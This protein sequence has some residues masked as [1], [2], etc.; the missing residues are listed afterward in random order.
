MKRS[1]INRI[2]TE[3]VTALLGQGYQ[4]NVD[5]MA[6][7]Q[8]EI[9]KVDLRKGDEILRVVLRRESCRDEGY[10]D[11]FAIT[12]GRNTDR[13]WPHSWDNTV[14]D[15]HLEILSQI[16][17]ANITEEYFVTPEESKAAAER[18]HEHWKRK[19]RIPHR[20]ELGDAFKSPA[21]R[22]L[23]KQPRMKTCKLEDIES[24]ARINQSGWRDNK[25]DLYGYEIKAKGKTFLL[26]AP[27]K[28]D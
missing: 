6:G 21:L 13:I 2:F 25:P 14:W 1:D 15:N 19:Y 26:K 10:D 11:Y 18:R 28:E 23:K 8:G 20:V 24:V 16:K 5:T 27:K 17:L 22:W 7:S 3:Q 4:I 9:A 12:I